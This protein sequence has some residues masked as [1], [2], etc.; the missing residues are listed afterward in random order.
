MTVNE[1]YSNTRESRWSRN[2]SGRFC[3][4]CFKGKK[5]FTTTRLKI[6]NRIEKGFY[7]M[8]KLKKVNQSFYYM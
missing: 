6:K 3:I 4:S 7:E 1:H 2:Q 8:K 5:P